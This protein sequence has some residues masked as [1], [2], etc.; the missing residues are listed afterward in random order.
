M[1]TQLV[2]GAL[3]VVATSA[4]VGLGASTAG[5]QT[6]DPS[7]AGTTHEVGT[8]I[9]CAGFAG[10]VPVRV[11]FY[12]NETYGNTLEVLVHDGTRREAGRTVETKKPFVVGEDV[13]A[14]TRVAGKKIRFHGTTEP[15]GKVK[16]IR[17]VRDDGGLHIVA[18][19]THTILDPKIVATYAGTAGKL[20]CDN[21]FHFN[22]E[23]TKTPVDN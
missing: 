16:R 11:N 21:A 23:V 5:A 6:P 19:G 8:V 12:E 7:A 4:L 10:K 14:R 22:L 13:L 20:T 18:R 1:R 2:T 3:A 9:E 17:D 15:T